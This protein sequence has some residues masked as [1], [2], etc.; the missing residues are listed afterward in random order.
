MTRA[1]SFSSCAREV[2]ISQKSRGDVQNMWLA[3]RSVQLLPGAASPHLRTS[4]SPSLT[5]WRRFDPSLC[6]I[7]EDISGNTPENER[8]QRRKGSD[9]ERE[10]RHRK[11]S[12]KG[13][14]EGGE[15]ESER[16]RERERDRDTETELDTCILVRM[17]LQ[18]RDVHLDLHAHQTTLLSQGGRTSLVMASET[19]SGSPLVCKRT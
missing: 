12:T 2:G 10:K 14:S 15:R 13:G 18:R 17:I 1:E 5:C 3:R 4:I 6:S 7:G 19:K 16:D 8:R 11:A 9:R